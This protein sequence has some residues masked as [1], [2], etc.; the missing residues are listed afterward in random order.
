MYCVLIVG[1]CPKYRYVECDNFFENLKLQEKETD[2]A[3][4]CKELIDEVIKKTKTKIP[5]ISALVYKSEEPI[6][7]KEFE[8]QGVSYYGEVSREKIKEFGIFIKGF[9]LNR[10]DNTYREVGIDR[11][12]Y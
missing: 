5:L 12:R 3:K 9:K 4:V 1:N 11:Q 7:I 2:L 10:L 8:F 6:R